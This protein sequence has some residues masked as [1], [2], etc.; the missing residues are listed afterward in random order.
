[1]KFHSR[2]KPYVKFQSENL[3]YLR[4]KLLE[5]SLGQKVTHWQ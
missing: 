2:S 4:R 5:V 1:M 3:E